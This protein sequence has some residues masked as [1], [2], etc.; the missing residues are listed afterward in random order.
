[1]SEEVK[2]FLKTERGKAIIKLSLY[3]IFFIVLFIF[4][5]PGNENIYVPKESALDKYSSMTNYEYTY[6]YDDTYIEGKTYRDILLFNIGDITY[7]Y[8]GII[9]KVMDN[10]LIIDELDKN[11]YINNHLINDYIKKGNIIGKNED[12]ENGI[13]STIYSVDNMHI[14]VFEKDNLINKV[15]IEIMGDESHNIEITYTNINKVSNFTLDFE[16]E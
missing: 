13:V 16:K 5:K 3:I 6:K 14:K 9:Y 4:V 7:Y 8:D 2:E 10:K 1:M 11:Y 15:S 12:Y